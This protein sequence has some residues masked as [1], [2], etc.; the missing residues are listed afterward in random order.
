M[1]MI[2]TLIMTLIMIMTLVIT[3]IM[4]LITINNPP[5][6]ALRRSLRRFLFSKKMS[7]KIILRIYKKKVHLC[8]FLRKL[9]KHGPPFPPPPPPWFPPKPSSILNQAGPAQDPAGA[10]ARVGAWESYLLPG[11]HPTSANMQTTSLENAD[12]NA[13]GSNA[14]SPVSGHLTR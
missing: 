2:M 10:G 11:M 4:T 12:P 9:I 1:I 6:L 7:E 8:V 14:L 13:P 5:V 3:L